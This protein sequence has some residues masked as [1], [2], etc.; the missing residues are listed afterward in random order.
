M[1]ADLRR[2]YLSNNVGETTRLVTVEGSVLRVGLRKNVTTSSL[3]G[4]GRRRIDGL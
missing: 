1:I 2:P 3:W 4:P